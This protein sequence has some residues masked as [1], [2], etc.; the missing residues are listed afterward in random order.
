MSDTLDPAHDA[1]SS[2]GRLSPGGERTQA[3]EPISDELQARLDKVIY[4][5]IGITT[6]LTRLKQSVASARDFSTFLKK[7]G[8]LEEEHAQGLRKLS[9][10]ISDASQRTEN[11]QGTYSSSYKDIHRIQERMVDHGLQFAVSLQ[12]MAD[13]LHELAGNIERGRKQWK[14]TGIAAEKKATDAEQSAE[15]AKVKYESLAEQYDRVRTGDK[16]GGKFGLKGHKSAAQHE[17]ELLRK[18]QNADSD[19]SSKVQ[20]AQAARQELISTNRP[21][22]VLNL[23]QLIAECDSGLTLQ[24]QKFATFSEKLLLGQG[25]CV[26]PM[27]TEDGSIGPKSLAQV[28]RQ[29]DNQKDLHEFILSHEGNP[30]A[31]ASEQI[32]Y[33]RHPTLGGAGATGAPVVATPSQPE[34]QNKRISILPQAF[35]SQHNLPPSGP[36]QPQPGDRLP[37]SPYPP[38][39]TFTPPPAGTAPPYPVSNPPAP[40]APPKIQVPMAGPNASDKNFQANLPPLKPVFGISLNDLYAR[41]GTAVPFIVYQCFQAV[42]LFGL[43]MEGIYRLSGS[44]THISHMKAVFDNDSSQVDFTNPENFYHDVNSVAGLVKQFF[45]DLPD[46]LFT[47]QFYHQ[48]IDAARFDDDIQRR[49]SLHALINSLPDAHYATLRAIILHLNKI[50]EHYTQNRMNAGNLAICFGP[51]LMGANS[52]GNIAD[53]GWQVRVIETILNNTFQIFDDD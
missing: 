36:Q 30:G 20:T 3:P 19:Y 2:S 27:K 50:Q 49:D 31:V 11:R 37:Q 26:S 47:S 46:P 40:E 51:T 14:Q 33:V 4:S 12:Q 38:E 8:S 34:S 6:L 5:D 13:D 9:R 32:Q 23:Q 25:L 39:K 35:S 16:Q 48:F 24:Q 15:K 28:V 17:E 41:D 42:E 29:V 18:V 7:R 52:G 43:S 21:Q 53:A 1:P 45:R 10:V 44:A 22:A